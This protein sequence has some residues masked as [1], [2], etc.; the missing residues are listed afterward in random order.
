MSVPVLYSNQT[1]VNYEQRLSCSDSEEQAVRVVKHP[2]VKWEGESKGN[3]PM[4]GSAGV[5]D[6]TGQFPQKMCHEAVT[7]A[8]I[9]GGLPDAN[10]KLTWFGSFRVSMAEGR[11]MPYEVIASL[12]AG[13][14]SSSAS[15]R[16]TVEYGQD[17]IPMLDPSQETPLKA[18][19]PTQTS[20]SNGLIRCRSPSAPELS[21]VHSEIPDK[22]RRVRQGSI[23]DI[24]QRYRGIVLVVAVPL[25]LV[26]FILFVVSSTPGSISRKAIPGGLAGSRSY[27]VIFDAGSS[28]SRVHVFCFDKNLDLL[29]IE[30]KLE[31]FEHVDDVRPPADTGGRDQTSPSIISSRAQDTTQGDSGQPVLLRP[32]LSNKPVPKSSILSSKAGD[33]IKPGLSAYANDP[34]QAADSLIPLLEKAESVIPEGLRHK[35]PVRVG[36]TAGLRALGDEASEQIL[37]AVRELLQ[38]KS[39]LKFQSDGVTVLDGTQE[40]AYQWVTINYLSG[41]L[42]KSYADT[43]GVVDLGGGSVQMAYAISEEDAKRAPKVSDGED[44]YVQKL[45]LK[46]SHYYLYV[47]SYLHYGLLAARAEILKISGDVSNC[48]LGGYHGSYE[49]GDET[50][51]ASASP[52]GASYSKCKDDAVKA[53]RVGEPACANMKCTFRGIWN[54]GG[55][56]GQKNLFVASFFFDR[57]SEAGFIDSNNP[58]AKVKPAEFEEAA[59]RACQLSIEDAKAAY[60]RVATDNLPYL[61]MDL[62]YQYALLVDGFDV[63]PNLYITLVKQVPYGDSFVE[64]AWPLGSAIEVASSP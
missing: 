9:N 33:V 61:C 36:A 5:Q 11:E 49:Y 58:V 22:M 29:H 20:S 17:S 38:H 47:H 42:G 6:K 52:S 48:I 13:D 2:T 43:V 50:Y 10:K 23:P 56:D 25:F 15:M 26:C 31:L 4:W 64:A 63:D 60:P 32:S 24:I 59:K 46:G 53:L 19:A 30:K 41:R 62:V 3:L 27:A 14:R 1:A 28:G 12:R 34:Q 57:A 7:I 21:R 51:K 8:S 35:T 55:G 39:S 44:S 54:G 45:F 16:R 40:G 18:P 37:Q